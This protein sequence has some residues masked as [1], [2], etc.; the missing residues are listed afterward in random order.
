MKPHHPKN[1]RHRIFEELTLVLR[2][3]CLL[4]TKTPLQ[5]CTE[6]LWALLIFSD[7][8]TFE[9]KESLVEKFGQLTDANQIRD[10]YTLLRLYL[11]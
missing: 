8:D 11:L 1:A 10:L 3:F 6:E 2:E 4:L 7:S 9:S 5:N